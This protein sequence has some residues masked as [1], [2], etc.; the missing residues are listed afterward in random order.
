MG[1]LEFSFLCSSYPCVGAQC[2]G[3]GCGMPTLSSLALFY[4]S[5]IPWGL[6]QDWESQQR[7]LRECR[8]GQSALPGRLS[9]ASPGDLD[10]GAAGAAAAAGACMDHHRGVLQCPQYCLLP[11][12]AFHHGLHQ[13]VKAHRVKP[14][15]GGEVGGGPERT[16]KGRRQQVVGYHLLPKKNRL[17]KD[18]EKGASWRDQV[19]S[20]HLSVWLKRSERE[21]RWKRAGCE[22]K[23]VPE[24]H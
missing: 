23:M 17:P 9:L 16:Q 2:V 8:R 22:N 4:S 19:G 1:T 6:K 7:L 20:R 5:Q 13:Q 12:K 21:D 11:T 10:S 15:V 18:R 14:G 3:P 24:M